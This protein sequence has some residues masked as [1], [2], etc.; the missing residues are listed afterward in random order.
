MVRPHYQS[1]R[2]SISVIFSYHQDCLGVWVQWVAVL[3]DT[4]FWNMLRSKHQKKQRVYPSVLHFINHCLKE[5]FIKLYGRKKL[6][7]RQRQPLCHLPVTS[8]LGMEQ[9]LDKK[10]SANTEGQEIGNCCYNIFPNVSIVWPPSHSTDILSEF[11]QTK[12]YFWLASGSFSP[13][14]KVVCNQVLT[15]SFSVCYIE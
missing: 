13:K 14:E 3:T 15:V 11:L 8:V 10:A 5:Y 9:L 2:C 4:C 7:Y 1:R 12:I 6:I